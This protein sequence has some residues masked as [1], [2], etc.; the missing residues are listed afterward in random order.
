MM[1]RCSFRFRADRPVPG[2]MSELRV[3]RGE[4][5]TPRNGRSCGI[6]SW[7]NLA[8]VLREET[9]SERRSCVKKV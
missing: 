5:G 8:I 6:A 1:L 4:P 9:T 2:S 7:L 3:M